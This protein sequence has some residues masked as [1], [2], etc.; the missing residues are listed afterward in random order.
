V[1]KYASDRCD[2]TENIWDWLFAQ[3]KKST[4]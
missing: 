3:K 4:E 1:T 2:K